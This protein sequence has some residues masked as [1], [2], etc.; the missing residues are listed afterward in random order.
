MRELKRHFSLFIQVSGFDHERIR[1]L[2]DFDE[3]LRFTRVSHDDEFHTSLNRTQHIIRLDASSIRQSNLFA[4]YKGT[5]FRSK[6]NS[7]FIRFRRQKGTPRLHL[8]NISKAIGP[9]VTH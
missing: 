4:R 9:A 6:W 8:K 2:A 1:I 5:A 7:E 3:V